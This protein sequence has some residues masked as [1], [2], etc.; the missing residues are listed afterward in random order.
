MKKRASDI[1]ANILTDSTF[2]LAGLVVGMGLRLLAKTT[3]L[4]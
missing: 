2:L 1:A 4:A 3:G